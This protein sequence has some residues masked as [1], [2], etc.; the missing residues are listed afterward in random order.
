[1]TYYS[2]NLE[3]FLWFLKRPHLYPHLVDKLVRKIT[4]GIQPFNRFRDDARKWYGVGA[5][6]LPAGFAKITSALPSRPVRELYP[7]VFRG[8]EER[9]GQSPSLMGGAGN[10][11]LLYWLAEHS[12]ATRILETGVARG[13]SSLVLLLSLANRSGGSLVSVDRPYIGL[14]E[15]HVGC[16]VPEELRSRWTLISR[17]DR[18][19]IPKALRLFKDGLDLCHYDSDKTYEG[20]MWAYPLLWKALRPEGMFLS[21]DL[22]DNFA[23]RDFADSIGVEP[24]IISY[25]KDYV[26]VIRKP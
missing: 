25:G 13:W 7:D 5:V 20:R 2:M 23:F 8:A 11:D 15:R 1:M 24:I 12:N 26:G 14:E 21:D 9:A 4:P 3:L 22:A 10:L 18:Q 16:V 19:G 17:A 6:D